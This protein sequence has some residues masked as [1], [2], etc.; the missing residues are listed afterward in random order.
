[1][2]DSNF[3]KNIDLRYIEIGIAMRKIDRVKPGKVPF[4]IPILTPEL[5]TS[6]KKD[7]QIIQRS[8]SHLVN[9]NPDAVEVSDIDT[10]NYIYIE[11]PV[12]LCAQSK[13]EDY[14]KGWL[15]LIGD[16]DWYKQL[17]GTGHLWGSGNLNGSGSVIEGGSFN[18]SGSFDVQ[19]GLEVDGTVQHWEAYDTEV[20]FSQPT[21]KSRLLRVPTE[22]WRF[23]PKYSKWII[24]FI[25][26]DINMPVVL[27]R[28]PCDVPNN[29]SVPYGKY[30]MG[31]TDPEALEKE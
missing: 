6:S 26:G 13:C 30:G 1:M 28:Y 24:A 18:V 22:P 14:V 27:C 2:A 31:D 15:H 11:I 9:E 25:G 20:V 3:Y 8:K 12:E 10:S 19:G 16:D 23:I 21:N 7:T 17:K 29:D 4:C 5:D